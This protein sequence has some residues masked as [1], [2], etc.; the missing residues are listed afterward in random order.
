ML[1]SKNGFE[2]DR[3]SI[4]KPYDSVIYELVGPKASHL[5]SVNLNFLHYK[6]GMVIYLYLTGSLLRLP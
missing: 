2:S 1:S 5:N 3:S 6:K 4:F